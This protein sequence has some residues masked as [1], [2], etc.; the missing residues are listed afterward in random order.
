MTVPRKISFRGCKTRDEAVERMRLWLD[1]I[2]ADAIR[3]LETRLIC[4]CDDDGDFDCVDESIAFVRA[5]H[6][7]A[8]E[9]MPREF[10]QFM[11]ENGIGPA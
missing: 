11:D 5:N 10:Q 8:R 3:E 9:E 1:D 4:E 2:H 6:A 7:E